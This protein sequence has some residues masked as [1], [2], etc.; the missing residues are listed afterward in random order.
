M[1]KVISRRRL[2]Y[3]SAAELYRE[4]YVDLDLWWVKCC[5][6]FDM[7]VDR[8]DRSVGENIYND[9]FWESWISAWVMNNICSNWTC[10]DIGAQH[11][12]YSF[13]LSKLTSG[14][15]A[16]E[17]NPYFVD[18]LNR[19]VGFGGYD[20]VDIMSIA[21]SDNKG[22]ATL[23]IPGSMLGS[24]SITATFDDAY[25]P[26]THFDVP[27]DTIDNLFP[28]PV[29]FMKI[30]A[31]GAEPQIFAG[32][33]NLIENHSPLIICEWAPNSY[34][35][36]PGFADYLLDTFNVTTI[37][38]DGYEFPTIKNNLLVT[39]WEMLVLRKRK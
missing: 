10:I 31:E 30:D 16:I 25:G 18:I 24:S 39:G 9:G 37:G 38:C 3:L 12:Y 21:I 17:P 7:F 8:K 35:D 29:D 11:G 14:V 32:M 1:D 2:E 36:A 27:T 23:S 15:T 19:T 13:M 28:G 20:N 4:Y 26:E 5:G 33:K 6:L 22:V 34:N